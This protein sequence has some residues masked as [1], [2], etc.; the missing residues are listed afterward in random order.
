VLPVA[1]QSV[2]TF[3]LLLQ[4]GCSRDGFATQLADHGMEIVEVTPAGLAALAR[5]EQRIRRE[6][7]FWWINRSPATRRPPASIVA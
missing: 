3:F 4:Y 1:D 7:G 5:P 2:P 6:K